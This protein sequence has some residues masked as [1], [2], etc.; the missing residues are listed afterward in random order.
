MRL[1][2]AV[3]PGPGVCIVVRMAR[4]NVYLPD[5]LHAR[6]R[7]AEL[8]VSELTQ[9]AIELE[10]DRQERLAAMDAFLDDLVQEAGPA[11]E[12]ERIDAETWARAVLDTAGRSARGEKAGRR[13]PSTKH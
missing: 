3:R 12:A 4:A 13:T 9:R 1:A 6:A 11:T 7:A 5:E 8:N 2:G 10:L